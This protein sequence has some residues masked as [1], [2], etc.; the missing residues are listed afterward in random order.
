MINLK[1]I[2]KRANKATP[3]PWK[4]VRVKYFNNVK[5]WEIQAKLFGNEEL[6]DLLE[7]P[8]KENAEFI[9]HAREDIVF[10]CDEIEC[11]RRINTNK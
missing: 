3:G 8:S 7:D 5:L 6:Y 11:L 2:K 1:P 10:L 4:A 9:A